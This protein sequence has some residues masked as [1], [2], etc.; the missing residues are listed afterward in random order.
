MVES[1]AAVA[2]SYFAFSR[3]DRAFE[4]RIRAEAEGERRMMGWAAREGF[5]LSGR[6]GLAVGAVV[7]DLL[8]MNMTAFF[9][10]PEKSCRQ[11]VSVWR[12]H[13]AC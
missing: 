12:L 8:L 3:K 6:D 11:H 13:E 9:R 5:W 4:R 7:D 2:G 1:E 10:T